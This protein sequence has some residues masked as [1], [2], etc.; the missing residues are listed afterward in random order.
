MCTVLLKDQGTVGVEGGRRKKSVQIKIRGK[1]L[2]IVAT[3]VC[4]HNS[5]IGD[6]QM[7]GLAVPGGTARIGQCM[8]ACYYGIES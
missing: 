7:V 1:N 4:S 3:V 6:R 5:D 8:I 2:G